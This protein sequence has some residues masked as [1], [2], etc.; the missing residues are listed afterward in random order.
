M[1]LKSRVDCQIA[2]IK[3][4]HPVVMPPAIPDQRWVPESEPQMCNISCRFMIC[5][6]TCQLFLEMMRKW[7]NMK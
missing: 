4:D 7:F 5:P 2:M 6:D 3:L 1:A